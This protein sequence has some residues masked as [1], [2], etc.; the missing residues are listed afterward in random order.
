MFPQLQGD[1]ED[2]I[3]LP[4]PPLYDP[5]ASKQQEHQTVEVDF[6]SKQEED[7]VNRYIINRDQIGSLE[8]VD[9]FKPEEETKKVKGQSII[10][11]LKS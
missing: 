8:L 10:I 1:D 11:L 5:A 3:I 7:D 2:W 6:K 9:S 4:Y